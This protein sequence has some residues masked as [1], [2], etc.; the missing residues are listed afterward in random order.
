[1]KRTKIKNNPDYIEKYHHNFS[2]FSY[3][4]YNHFKKRKEFIDKNTKKFLE[5]K[6]VQENFSKIRILVI[7]GSYPDYKFLDNDANYFEDA[8][9]F[10][11][12]FLIC[13]LF[14]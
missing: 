3:N 1:M 12:A 11:T 4:Y 8:E 10:T 14:D 5:D 7:I 13:Y 6:N 9:D 2:N